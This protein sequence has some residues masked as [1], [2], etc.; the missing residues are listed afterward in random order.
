MKLKYVSGERYKA[1]SI[2]Q[3]SLISN[4][5]NPNNFVIHYL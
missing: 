1:L 4:Q 5:I 2:N 3:I